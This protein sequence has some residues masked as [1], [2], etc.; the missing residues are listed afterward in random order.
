MIP[1]AT[2]GSSNLGA[3][4]LAA[5]ACLG[6]GIQPERVGLGMAQRAARSQVFAKRAVGAG[7][8]LGICAL[9]IR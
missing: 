5:D 2:G 8:L 9:P 4:H 1:R 7:L 6:A 3:Q